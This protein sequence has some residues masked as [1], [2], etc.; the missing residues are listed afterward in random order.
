MNTRLVRSILVVILAAMA[1]RAANHASAA[2]VSTPVFSVAS[3][4][5]DQ[6][7]IIM[8]MLLVPGTKAIAFMNSPSHLTGGKIRVM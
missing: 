4:D 7:S 6:T 8:W 1:F 2:P 5:A 3:G